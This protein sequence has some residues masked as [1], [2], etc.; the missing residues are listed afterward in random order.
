MNN[1]RAVMSITLLIVLIAVFLSTAPAVQAD[2][3]YVSDRL[4]ITMR[5]GRGTEYRIIR[6]LKTGTPVEVLEEDEQYMKVRTEDGREGWVLKRYITSETPKTVVIEGLRAERDRLK[7]GLDDL[8]RRIAEL[9]RELEKERQA[10]RSEQGRLKKEIRAREAELSE[11]RAE[12]EA[13]NR[14]YRTFMDASKN[15]VE[16]I[17]ER[18]LLRKERERLA[19]DKTRLLR[20]NEKLQERGMIYWFLAGGGVFFVGWVSGKLSRK[21]KR[22]Y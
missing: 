6:T 5:E 13:V 21:K 19:A 18:D 7:A 2:T 14:K 16:I 17:K 10:R 1:S 8:N 22:Y 9:R 3:R 11:V 4:V 15:V 20:E 12:L